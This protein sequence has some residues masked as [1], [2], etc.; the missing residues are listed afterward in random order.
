[1]PPLSR[2][3]ARAE[4]GSIYVLTDEA[5]GEILRL[6]PD[7]SRI[8]EADECHECRAHIS[9]V[10]DVRCML[11]FPGSRPQLLCADDRRS[12]GSSSPSTSIL[13]AFGTPSAREEASR[14]TRSRRLR[15][16]PK[17]TC[18]ETELSTAAG[19]DCGRVERGLEVA[20]S[21]CCLV[22]APP[23]PRELRPN[24]SNFFR[25]DPMT[26]GAASMLSSNRGTRAS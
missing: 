2:R 5:N 1:M 18:A 24:A 4:N 8:P 6:A 17:W 9:V 26:A 11:S 13:R 23:W 16:S 22:A 7:R 19:W 10:S 14:S 15:M 12:W 21:P 3:A 25:C 20:G